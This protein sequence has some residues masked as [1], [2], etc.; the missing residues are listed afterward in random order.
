MQVVGLRTKPA[1]VRLAEGQWRGEGGNN[2]AGNNVALG[3][4]DPVDL[5]DHEMFGEGVVEV[6]FEEGEDGGHKIG[7]V[8]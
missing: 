7:M 4:L 2:V 5:M 8:E 6:E 1:G 3:R